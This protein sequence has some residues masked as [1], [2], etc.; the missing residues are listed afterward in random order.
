MQKVILKSIVKS[1]AEVSQ[2]ALQTASQKASPKPKQKMCLID[3]TKR[4]YIYSIYMNSK[5]GQLNLVTSES[6]WN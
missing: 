5:K 2:K 6:R 4:R 3:F 1:P